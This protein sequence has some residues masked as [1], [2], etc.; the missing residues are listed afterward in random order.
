MW[1]Y[2]KDT[3]YHCLKPAVGMY[4]AYTNL[5][6]DEQSLSRMHSAYIRWCTWMGNFFF[7]TTFFYVS[8]L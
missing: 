3:G 8:V 6:H 7:V 5:Q 1:V 4:Y 2:M